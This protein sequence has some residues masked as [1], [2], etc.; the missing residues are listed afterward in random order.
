MSPNA[1]FGEARLSQRERFDALISD[2]G[3]F[4]LHCAGA[5]AVAVVMVACWIALHRVV[6]I[7]LIPL[8]AWFAARV[9][10]H[11]GA[12]FVR[13]AQH[14]SVERWQGRYY[15]YNGIHLRFFEVDG[16]IVFLER[17]ILAIFDMKDSSLIALF[18]PFERVRETASGPWGLTRAG[19]ERL[20]AKIVHPEAGKLTLWLRRQ[21]YGPHDRKRAST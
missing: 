20:L 1:T 9:F 6:A 14:A 5:L 8:F 21:V 12:A 16:D 3:R 15:E 10:V 17:D 18:G 19:C 4:L 13:H 11:F 7:L 2:R